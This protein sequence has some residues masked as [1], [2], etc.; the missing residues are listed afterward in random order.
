MFRLNEE[1]KK[2]IQRTVGL[3]VE[4]LARFSSGEEEKYIAKQSGIPL[5]FAVGVDSRKRGRGNPY[6]ALGRITR[7]E[8]IEKKAKAIR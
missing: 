1:A 8:E 2:A 3:S 7:P 6:L 4:E 5:H